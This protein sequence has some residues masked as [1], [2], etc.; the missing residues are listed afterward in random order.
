MAK[1]RKQPA[2]AQTK[3]KPLKI[4]GT[5][6]GPIELTDE[7]R[8]EAGRLAGIGCTLDQ[9]AI[10]L[11]ISNTCLDQI[12]KRDNATKRAIEMGRLNAHCEVKNTLY[13]AAV[14][15]KEMGSTMFFLKTQCGWREGVTSNTI[16]M[17]ATPENMEHLM[18]LA[19]KGLEDAT[20]GDDTAA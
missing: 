1:A 9:I 8:E 3:A 18:R 2:L 15:G 13:Q 4:R 6:N 19:R 5:G 10:Y 11:D 17:Q 7:E 14:S 12:I 20:A 16:V